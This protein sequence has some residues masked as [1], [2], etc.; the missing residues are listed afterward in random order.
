[1]YTLY[2]KYLFPSQSGEVIAAEGKGDRLMH[3]NKLLFDF[4]PLTCMTSADLVQVEF[5]TM[6]MF[7]EHNQMLKQLRMFYIDLHKMR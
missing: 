4:E 7:Y 2:G 5:G 6:R 1:M 3:R